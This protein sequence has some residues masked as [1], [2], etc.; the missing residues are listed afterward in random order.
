MPVVIGGTKGKIHER[1]ARF[2]NGWFA[3]TADADELA[4][5]LGKI[6]AR[7]ED[8]SRDFSEIENHLLVAG[9]WRKGRG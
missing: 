6:K 5:H 9:Y 4:G 1:I 8:I 7:C 3:V 2:G